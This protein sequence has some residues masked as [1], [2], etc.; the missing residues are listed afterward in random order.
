MHEGGRH[1]SVDSMEIC[2]HR[3]YFLSTFIWHKGREV[4]FVVMM[5]CLAVLSFYAIEIC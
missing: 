4:G 2:C 5:T 3:K 1:I